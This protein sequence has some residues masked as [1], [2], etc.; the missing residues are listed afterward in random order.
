MQLMWINQQ[1]Q[2]IWQ[3]SNRLLQFGTKRLERNLAKQLEI[4]QQ[5][6]DEVIKEIQGEE[7][8]RA[9]DGMGLPSSDSDE[10]T[11]ASTDTEATLVDTETDRDEYHHL[12]VIH[13]SNRSLVANSLETIFEDSDE[14]AVEYGSEA[15]QGTP[16]VEDLSEDE[17]YYSMGE[18]VEE[19]EDEGYF[20]MEE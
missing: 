16:E 6:L 12:E 5:R 13:P 3:E 11:L 2:A 8:T 9:E 15:D 20:S 1:T 4:W 14:T 10:A 17:G 7:R 19:Q 18:M